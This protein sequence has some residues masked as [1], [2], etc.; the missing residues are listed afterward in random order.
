MKNNIIYTLMVLLVSIIV[1]IP[2]GCGNAQPQV[3]Q[4]ILDRTSNPD[5]SLYAHSG[6]ERFYRISTET[7]GDNSSIWVDRETGAEY[8]YIV[9]ESKTLAGVGAVNIQFIP[10]L[11]GNGK[12]VIYSKN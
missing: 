7:I 3:T 9:A 6:E 10:L 1:L 12:P 5:K 11:D 4:E 8:L 2:I